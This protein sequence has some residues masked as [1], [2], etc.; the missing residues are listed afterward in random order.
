MENAMPVI[1][2]VIVLAMAVS[3]NGQ[4]RRFFISFALGVVAMRLVVYGLPQDWRYLASCAV[5]V[6]VGAEAI[7]RGIIVPGALLITSGLCYVGQEVTRLAPVF[8]NPWLV[9]ADLCGWL[10][11]LGVYR[12]RLAGISD[13]VGPL[14]RGA[15]GRR[16]LA[17]HRNLAAQACPREVKAP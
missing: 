13:Q 11:L 5:W 1:A 3:T 6:T 4:A 17:C 10:A 12:G 9:A 15:F 2:L 14:V 7:R 16:D 8:G